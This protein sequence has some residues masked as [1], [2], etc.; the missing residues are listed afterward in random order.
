MMP[1]II[2]KSNDPKNDEL[3]GPTI[4]CNPSP[5][6]KITQNDKCGYGPRI[7]MLIISPY[8]KENFIEYNKST[9]FTSILKFIEDN[10]NLGRIGGGSLDAKAQSLDNMFDFKSQHIIPLILNPSTGEKS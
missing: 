7:P 4:L 10:W 9:D 8:A 1:P 6:E 5:A 2:S 3:Y